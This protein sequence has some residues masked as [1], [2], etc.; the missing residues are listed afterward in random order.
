MS[1][2]NLITEFS[3]AASVRS[4][5]VWHQTM[6]DQRHDNE[7]GGCSD[8]GSAHLLSDIYPLQAYLDTQHRN[9]DPIA[10]ILVSAQVHSN[11]HSLEDRL[12]LNVVLLCG[13]SP[14]S[15]KRVSLKLTRT[16][17]RLIDVQMA[18][19][20]MPRGESWTSS[21]RAQYRECSCSEVAGTGCSVLTVLPRPLAPVRHS[22]GDVASSN[23]SAC[24]ESILLLTGKLRQETVLF[25]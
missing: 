18:P 8:G 19:T 25:A 2:P 15:R 1:C 16:K 13:S 23:A 20:G 5:T 12:E 10:G 17:K 24:L 6:K 4:D 3:S 9:T 7:F 22:I 11:L 14:E 21:A